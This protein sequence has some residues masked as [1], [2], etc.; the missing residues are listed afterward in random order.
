MMNVVKRIGMFL[1]GGFVTA[2]GVTNIAIG[3][4]SVINSVGGNTDEE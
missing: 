1:F 4:I 3:T 2:I